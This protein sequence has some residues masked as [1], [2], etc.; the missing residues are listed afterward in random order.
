ML[1]SLENKIEI[2]SFNSVVMNGFR[3]YL[4]HG[5]VDNIDLCPDEFFK[6]GHQYGL[7]DIVK[8]AEL[9]M[10]NQINLRTYNRFHELT[11]TF[12]ELKLLKSDLK[13]FLLKYS[14]T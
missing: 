12:E 1:E 7:D 11:L 8:L 3:S 5:F 4:Y 2:E 9:Q 6:F 10:R 14:T 13:A